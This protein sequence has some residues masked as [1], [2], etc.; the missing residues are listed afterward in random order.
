[1]SSNQNFVS[2]SCTGDKILPDAVSSDRGAH[3]AERIRFMSTLNQPA[4]S[5]LTA[6]S[7]A[8]Y[9]TT[10]ILHESADYRMSP[11]V[12][13]MRE[14]FG[15][16]VIKAI[17][18]ISIHKTLQ[19][20]QQEQPHHIPFTQANFITYCLTL[21][22][23]QLNEMCIALLIV[24]S[25]LTVFRF[26]EFYKPGRLIQIF[27]IRIGLFQFLL[28][29]C[30]LWQWVCCSIGTSKQGMSHNDTANNKRLGNNSESAPIQPP[31][32]YSEKSH[33]LVILYTTAYLQH[34]MYNL[35]VIALKY[36]SEKHECFLPELS[37]TVQATFKE[38]WQFNN[39]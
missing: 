35:Q 18:W 30:H 12:S 27:R 36:I 25:E 37:H 29:Y 31:Q 6:V 15:C 28:Q 20:I 39:L 8:Y 38:N 34:F 19:I 10:T 5:V 22:I 17:E 9:S 3:I 7:R 24:S 33:C 16:G 14:A 4:P 13:I 21:E 23:F 32:F 26:L 1:M 2:F 11:T